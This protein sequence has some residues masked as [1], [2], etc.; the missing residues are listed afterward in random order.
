MKKL[1]IAFGTLLAGVGLLWS[2]TSS[3]ENPVDSEQAQSCSVVAWIPYWDQEAAMGSVKQHADV[4]D[5]VS[6]FWYHLAPNGSVRRYQ[7]ANVDPEIIQ[8]AHDKG[9]KVLA[10]VANLPDDQ[11]DDDD[12]DDWDP[13]R[14]EKVIGSARARK[15]HIAELL[16]LTEKMGFDGINIDY[17]A[18]PGELRKDFTRFSRELGEAL[19]AKDK[20]LAV[21]LH[22]K[23]AEGIPSE[24]NG[25]HAQDWDLL[26]KYVDQLH[27][28]TYGEH[29][30]STHPGPLASPDWLQPI[31]H[32]AREIREVPAEKLFLGIPVYA[33]A[34]EPL[35]HGRFRAAAF[36]LSYVDV[37]RA[38]QEY[39]VEPEWDEEHSSPRL[40]FESDAGKKRIVWFEN[41]TSVDRKLAVGRE[42][43][44]C[45]VGL[46]RLG[47]EDPDA[48]NSLRENKRPN[49]N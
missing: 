4:V 8:Y 26:P 7:D 43:G 46:W 14:V 27:L 1:A 15:A 19:H 45:N 41:R 42:F 31:L 34:W 39:D 47:G 12:S 44:I 20:I 25:S 11:R 30:S 5:Y 13:D 38:E 37:K 2:Y 29:N 16:E 3:A 22:P 33:E 28:M 32:Y 36:N 49:E 9:M 24:D 35:G 17:E 10:L 40:V 23:T 18:L 21:A 6:V 48:W